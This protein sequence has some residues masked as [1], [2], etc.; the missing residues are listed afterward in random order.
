MTK[1]SVVAQLHQHEKYERLIAATKGMP[2]LP[3]AVAHPC[4]E[5]S[6][7][8]ALEAAD[9]GTIV[10]ILVGPQEKNSQPREISW[11]G[12]QGRRDRRRPSQS[13]GSSESRRTRSD[14]EGRAVDEGKPTF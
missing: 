6:L 14:G 10:P 3:T 8:G 11:S 5:T 1:K 13:G 9:A 12:H 7:R 4:D 2:A